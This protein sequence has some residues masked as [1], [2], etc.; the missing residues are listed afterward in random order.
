LITKNEGLNFLYKFNIFYYLAL[1]A[2][3]PPNCK[4]LIWS[5]EGQKFTVFTY[6]HNICFVF[7]YINGNFFYVL[8]RLYEAPHL[9]FCS[10]R[11]YHYFIAFRNKD[12][13][14]SSIMR[15]P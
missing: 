11:C 2:I 14:Y 13:F 6:S 10:P 5:C 4:I 8:F 15:F 1:L 9:Y 3:N 12:P 7:I